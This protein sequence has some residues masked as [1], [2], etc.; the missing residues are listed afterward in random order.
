M[1]LKLVVVNRH[2]VAKVHRSEAARHNAH[3]CQ[4]ELGIGLDQRK[5]AEGVYGP[6]FGVGA[7]ED[8][9][10]PLPLIGDRQFTDNT[11]GGDRLVNDIVA[12]YLEHAAA[13]NIESRGIVTLSKQEIPRAD[14][15][16]ID[17]P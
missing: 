15:Y 16:D 11:A 12:N 4:C 6:Q 14:R 10:A 3:D 1:G 2:P 9:R 13:D 5:E 17:H 8:R 7:R